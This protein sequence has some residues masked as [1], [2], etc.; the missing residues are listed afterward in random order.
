MFGLQSGIFILDDILHAIM[1][2]YLKL[3]YRSLTV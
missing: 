1:Q 3:C 2:F